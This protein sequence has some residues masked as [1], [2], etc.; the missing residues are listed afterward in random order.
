MRTILIAAVVV[1]SVD[2][3]HGDNN[4]HLRP[5]QGEGEFWLSEKLAEKF[6]PSACVH[7]NAPIE[8]DGAASVN[9]IVWGTPPEPGA[10][11]VS[12]ELTSEQVQEVQTPA[13]AKPRKPKAP[14]KPKTEKSTPKPP[15]K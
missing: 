15:K 13:T 12:L 2:N 3:G 7:C 9:E 11:V 6:A 1:D 5:V 10:E 14:A 8:P 4:L